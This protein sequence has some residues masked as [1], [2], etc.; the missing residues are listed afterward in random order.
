MLTLDMLGIH[1]ATIVSKPSK[2][3]TKCGIENLVD[4]KYTK[5][6]QPHPLGITCNLC[7]RGFLP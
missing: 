2:I 5:Y 1:F 4:L 3:K 7:K 6:M